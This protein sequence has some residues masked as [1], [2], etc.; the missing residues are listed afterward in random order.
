MQHTIDLRILWLVM[1]FAANT[2]AAASLGGRYVEESEPTL[3]L[4]LQE[5][6]EGNITGTLAAQGESMTLIAKRQGDG[7][8]GSLGWADEAMPVT[9][10]MR[11]ER[12]ILTIGPSEIG[13]Q[14]TF[15]RANDVASAADPIAGQRNVVING[16]RLSEEELTR[17]EQAYQIHVPDADYWYD[18]VLG[19]WGARG[20]PTIGFVLPG[21]ALG[22][23]LQPDASGGGT[24]VFVNGRALHPYDL[25]ALQQITGPIVPGRYFITAQGYA[26]YEGG[27]PLWNLGALVAQSQGGGG[28][29]NTWQSRVTGASGFS[30]GE[31]GAVFLPNGGIV[32][33]GP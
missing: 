4:T 13:E 1:M 21:L 3:T 27:P 12:I 9:A 29:T 31:Y 6:T 22:G 20:G 2:A 11:S 14:L 18:R 10:V 7:F 24:N 26:G 16:V 25:M 5:S 30:Y 23:P 32:T 28:G 15:R 19:A 17:V 8:A 33:T